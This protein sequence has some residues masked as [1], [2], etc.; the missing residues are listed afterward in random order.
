MGE[1][2]GAFFGGVEPRWVEV[3]EHPGWDAALALVNRDVGV[4]LPEE[5][6]LRLVALPGYEEGAPESVYVALANGEW[7]GNALE[8]GAEE[9][10]RSALAAVAE[11][12]QDTVTE[13]LWRA[14]PVCDEHRLGTHVREEDGRVVWWCAGER[15]AGPGHVVAGVGELTGVGGAG[16]RRARRKRR[17]R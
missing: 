2:W 9:E 4:T 12:A 10:P 13:R 8:P 7:H 1:S 16:G 15:R 11:A 17:K 6:P 5:E 3:G 14:W